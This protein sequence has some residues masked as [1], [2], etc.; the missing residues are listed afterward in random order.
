MMMCKN[1]AQRGE[2]RHQ[3]NARRMD[4]VATKTKMQTWKCNRPLFVHHRSSVSPGL[5]LHC[6]A[7]TET[8][9]GPTEELLASLGV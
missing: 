8:R 9:S 7:S 6:T 2:Q 3:P 1:A 4:E 5:V